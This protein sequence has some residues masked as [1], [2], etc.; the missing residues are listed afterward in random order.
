LRRVQH[1]PYILGVHR[2]VLVSLLWMALAVV[3]EKGV[4]PMEVS[5]AIVYMFHEYMPLKVT[6]PVEAW[7]F[8]VAI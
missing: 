5:G 7:Q 4:L 8:A 1:L 3:F 6:L 2:V